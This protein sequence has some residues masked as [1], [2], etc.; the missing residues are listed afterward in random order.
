VRGSQNWYL[1]ASLSQDWPAPNTAT[2]QACLDAV[3]DDLL[4]SSLGFD[5]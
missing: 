4:V 1:R 2:L 3:W 5:G